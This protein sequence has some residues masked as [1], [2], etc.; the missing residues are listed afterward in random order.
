MA[1]ATLDQLVARFEPLL[2]DQVAVGLELGPFGFDDL[3]IDRI[4]RLRALAD[5]PAHGEGQEGGQSAGK[6]DPLPG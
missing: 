3:A 4:G 5:E 2:V 6:H 1:Y